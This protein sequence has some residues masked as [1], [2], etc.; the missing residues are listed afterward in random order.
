MQT[1]NQWKRPKNW[2]VVAS[3]AAASALG[4]S[5]FALASDDGV[6]KTPDSI[7]LDDT[8]KVTEVTNPTKVPTT[9]EDAVQLGADTASLDSPFDDDDFDSQASAASQASPVSPNSP[10][11]PASPVSQDS[12][13][14]AASPVSQDSPVSAASPASPVSQDSPASAASPASADSGN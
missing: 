10:V 3:V 4:L 13:V 2:K 14:S 7:S 12:P 1:R 11:S 5:G 8:T 6:A 9:V